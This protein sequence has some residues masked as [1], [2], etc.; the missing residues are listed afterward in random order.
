MCQGSGECKNEKD[1]SCPYKVCSQAGQTAKNN[2][3]WLITVMMKTMESIEWKG[4][5]GKEAGVLTWVWRRGKSENVGTL[6]QES[7]LMWDAPSWVWERIKTPAIT[8]EHTHTYAHAHRTKKKHPQGEN[9]AERE[10]LG[11]KDRLHRPTVPPR[12]MLWTLNR[13]L[14]LR[15]SALSRAWGG[16]EGAWSAQRARPLT[17]EPGEFRSYCRWLVFLFTS[18]PSLIHLFHGNLL[19]DSGRPTL[20]DSYYMPGLFQTLLI[21]LL[22]N[23]KI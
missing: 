10:K 13:T 9:S 20:T 2:L 3:L 17:R 23:L 14:T 21:T 12:P 22:N 18:A 11:L 15:R 1:S 6:D 5:K 4:I 7:S 16:L 19:N 8:F